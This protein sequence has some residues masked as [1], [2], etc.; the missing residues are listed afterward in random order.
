[1]ANVMLNWQS[2]DMVKITSVS[3]AC[4]TVKRLTPVWGLQV[5]RCLSRLACVTDLAFGV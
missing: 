3:A 4:H 5:L 2:K 1:M